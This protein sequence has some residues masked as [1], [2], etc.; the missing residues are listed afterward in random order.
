VLTP[1][2]TAVTAT[3]DTVST[4]TTVT[5]DNVVSDTEVVAD[6]NVAAAPGTYPVTVN[7]SQS[8]DDILATFSPSK[9]SDDVLLGMF[10]NNGSGQKNLVA[11]VFTVAELLPNVS[12]TYVNTC[13][14]G[15]T[16]DFASMCNNVLTYNITYDELMQAIKAKGYRPVNLQEMIAI[17]TKYPTIS[18]SALGSIVK[19]TQSVST[20]KKPDIYVPFVNKSKEIGQSVAFSFSPNSKFNIDNLFNITAQKDIL[21]VPIIVVQDSFWIPSTV[22]ALS[23]I[24][25]PT[26][27]LYN[28]SGEHYAVPSLKYIVSVDYSKYT[29]K[30]VYQGSGTEQKVMKFLTIKDTKA[31]KT[32]LKT[33]DVS[34]VSYGSAGVAIPAGYRVAT[35]AE[36][37]SLKTQ[38]PTAGGGM[39]MMA[40]GSFNDSCKAYPFIHPRSG[41]TQA[42]NGGLYFDD[43]RYFS[44]SGIYL[45]GSLGESIS[46]HPEGFNPKTSE[47]LFPI[48][49]I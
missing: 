10:S 23:T 22:S 25:M 8:F 43:K 17:S 19:S 31:Y 11:K 44:P 24:G 9:V 41:W 28:G 12:S 20:T 46:A 16:G 35:A 33:G 5:A 48:V 29:Y 4:P 14:S 39:G 38:Y 1:T 27:T 40:L 3:V 30:D 21:T 47:M 18:G 32:T 26:L 7:Y 2:Q 45:L 34:R 15:Y 13:A 49:K 42:A 36:M 37:L 6:T